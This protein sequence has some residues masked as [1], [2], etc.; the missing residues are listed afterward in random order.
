MKY[1]KVIIVN[2]NYPP[3][4]GI[5]GH[6]AAE[7]AVFLEQKGVEVSVVHANGKYDGGGGETGKAAGRIYRTLNLYNGK[8][9]FLRLFSSF[10]ESFMLVQKAKRLGKECLIIV[11]TDPPFLSF[12]AAALLKKR[13]WISWTMDLYPEAF[14][15][16]GLVSEKNI[17]YN[18]LN[19]V[20]Y[21]SP[22]LAMINL[23]VHQAAY[24]Q[25]KYG[26]QI[27]S[28]ILPCGIWKR[29]PE[30]HVPDWYKEPG[31]LYLGYCG[32][33]GQAHSALFI[34]SVIQALDPEKFVFILSVYGSHS[35]ELL[36]MAL[37]VPGVVVL[38]SV[39]RA[40]LEFIDVHLITLKS[41]WEHICV[42]SKAVSAVCGGGAILFCGTENND[43]WHYLK[44]AGW[45]INDDNTLGERINSIL[46]NLNESVVRERRSKAV[47]V[48]TELLDVRETAF[49]E[50]YLFLKREP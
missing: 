31:K 36:E 1:S 30:Q 20:V 26:K 38:K 6:S 17:F 4:A 21:N 27:S 9:A 34:K 39:P 7:L 12:W 16:G 32:N 11:M 13:S 5:T 28:F 48:A 3:G 40:H 45:R 49:Q 19:G 10:V 14:A 44:S 18:F 22:P 33:V 46:N 47:E 23:G 50:I 43:N 41:N 35:K 37:A 2:K 42:P 29:T 15:A 25:K 24:L 8:N